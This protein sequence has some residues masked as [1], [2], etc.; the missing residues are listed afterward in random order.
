MFRLTSVL[1]HFHE[2]NFGFVVEVSTKLVSVK[3]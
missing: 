2:T 3:V 1:L